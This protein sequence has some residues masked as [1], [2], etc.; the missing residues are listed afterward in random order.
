MQP[1][2][3]IPH[4]G[5]PCFFMDW[6]M[7]PADTWDNLAAW[8]GSISSTLPARPKAILVISA[9]WEESTVTVASNANPPLI[10][11]YHGF[12]EHTYQIKY[13]VPGAPDIAQQVQQLLADAG[14]PCQQDAK[15]GLDHGV[16]IPFKLIYPN[17]DIPIVQLS[18]NSN[19]DPADHVALGEALTPLREQNVLV[20]GSG[21]S[22]HNMRLLQ[23]GGCNGHSDRFDQWLTETCLLPAEQRNQRLYQWKQAPSG[24]QS[25]PREEHLLPLM[26]VAGAAS[27]PGKRV[28]N[29]RVLNSLV[30]GFRF[31]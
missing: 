26:V 10:Y 11:D 9:H 23:S 6:T 27:E 1:T 7:G 30:S 12:P 18:L 5:G 22:F 14:I 21:L 2:F 4:G 13:P 8:L 15:R 29:G 19:L 31:D 17:A 24:L 16:F 20:I 25:H 28:F 3:Y